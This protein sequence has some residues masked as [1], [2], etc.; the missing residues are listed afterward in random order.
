MKEVQCSEDVHNEIDNE[1]DQ[2]VKDREAV[3]SIFPRGD[4]RVVLPCNIE[5]IIWN[6]QKIFNLNK[7]SKSDLLPNSIVGKVHELS[8]KLIIVSGNDRLSLEAQNNATLLFKIH[9]RASLASRRVIQEY[10]LNSE[11]FDWVLGE[12]ESKF[13]AAIVHPGSFLSSK[14]GSLI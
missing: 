14:R 8:E 5:R 9:L 4:S 1:F 10:Y 12:I 2:L 7:M 11:A 13:N 3:R 6:A